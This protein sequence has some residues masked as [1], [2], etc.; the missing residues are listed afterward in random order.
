MLKRDCPCGTAMEIVTTQVD[1]A[2][3]GDEP[4]M[5]PMKVWR[6]TDCKF[7]EPISAD[8]EALSEDRPQLPGF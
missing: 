4:D 1:V 6:C 7:E 2:R 8:V 5:A 3:L